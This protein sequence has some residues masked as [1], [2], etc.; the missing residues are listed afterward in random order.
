MQNELAEKTA[1]VAQTQSAVT[2]ADAAIAEA[3]SVVQQRKA[4]LDQVNSRTAEKEAMLKLNENQV[5]PVGQTCRRRHDWA[6]QP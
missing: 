1:M 4:E 5:A 6:G 3:E 2:Q